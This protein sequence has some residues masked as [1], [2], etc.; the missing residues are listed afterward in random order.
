RPG[1][2]VF[3]NLCTGGGSDCRWRTPLADRNGDGKPEFV[4]SHIGGWSRDSTPQTF[5][6]DVFL[7]AGTPAITRVDTPVVLPSGA[8]R[9][10]ANVRTGSDGS[11]AT[12]GGGFGVQ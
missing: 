1:G 9:F 3:F 8:V 12:L 2:S 4:I 7:S 11:S 6:V 5:S 10:G